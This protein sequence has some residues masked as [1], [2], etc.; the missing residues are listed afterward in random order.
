MLVAHQETEYAMVKFP[1]GELVESLGAGPIL[2]VAALAL[3]TTLLAT[4][5]KHGDP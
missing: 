2:P 3:L 5:G 4:R 1:R